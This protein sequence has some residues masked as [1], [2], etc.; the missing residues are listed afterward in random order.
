MHFTSPD[1][2]DL[3]FPS[4]RPKNKDISIHQIQM[5]CRAALHSYSE[6]QYVV[7]NE[8]LVDLLL[9]VIIFC[10]DLQS[11][12]SQ[13][14]LSLPAFKLM[15][16]CPRAECHGVQTLPLDMAFLQVYCYKHVQASGCTNETP[17][18]QSQE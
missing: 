5:P 18:N 15:S 8:K 12:K 16:L 2:S 14:T 6:L 7:K 10:E 11:S 17:G 1:G 13:F 3:S 9:L 4:R